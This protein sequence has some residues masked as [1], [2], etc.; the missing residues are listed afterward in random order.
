MMTDPI[1]DMLTRIRNANTRGHRKVDL[2]HSNLKEKIADVLKKEGFISDYKVTSDETLKEKKK[3]LHIYLKYTED[4]TKVINKI[5]R[6]S[7][8]GRR[9]FTKVEDI[10]PT[11]GGLGIMVLSTSR[12]IMA[13]KEAK[14]LNVG[15]EVIC[16]VW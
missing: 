10:K 8:P 15:G 11:L 14:K 7:K 5:V 2:P 4:N 13:D 6:I 12:G 3:T 1:A 9:V 16:K